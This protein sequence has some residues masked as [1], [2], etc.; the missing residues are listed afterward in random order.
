MALLILLLMILAAVTGVLGT[1]L[2]GAA[3]LFIICVAALACAALIRAL[4]NREG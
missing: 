4:S 1:V 3:W 2:K